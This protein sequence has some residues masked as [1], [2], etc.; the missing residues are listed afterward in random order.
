MAEGRH[1]TVNVLGDLLAANHLWADSLAGENKNVKTVS[2]MKFP[3]KTPEDIKKLAIYYRFEKDSRFLKSKVSRYIREAHDAY[4]IDRDRYSPRWVLEALILGGCDN[5][6]AG[7]HCGMSPQAV[8]Y[9]KRFYFNLA[10][11]N[12][13]Q[14]IVR[15]NTMAGSFGEGDDI[16]WGYK[17]GVLINGL[18]WFIRFYITNEDT[19]EDRKKAKELRERRF[20]RSRLDASLLISNED[21][22]KRP[23]F[24]EMLQAVGGTYSYIQKD[25]ELELKSSEGG[26]GTTDIF[27]DLIAAGIAKAQEDEGVNPKDIKVSSFE[28]GIPAEEKLPI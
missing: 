24:V 16:R 26:G 18:D 6:G 13:Q 2:K 5:K 23:Q 1:R 28:E 3:K 17:L 25:R 22:Y 21:N 9:Y 8:S 19:P 4:M 10:G 15:C 27:S 14:L 7:K 12:R 11:D 20:E